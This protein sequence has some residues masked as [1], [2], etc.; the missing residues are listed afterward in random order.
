MVSVYFYRLY[1]K[2]HWTVER[3]D[4]EP[5]TSYKSIELWLTNDQFNRHNFFAQRSWFV[6][7]ASKNQE[8]YDHRFNL[9]KGKD[10]I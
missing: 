9:I 5:P 2:S 8:Q 7:E 4:L 6:Y 1:P 10:Y 3:F